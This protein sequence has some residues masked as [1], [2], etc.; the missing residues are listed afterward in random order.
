[1]QFNSDADSQDIVSDISFLTGVDTT[2]FTLKNRTLAVNGAL[3]IAWQIIFESYGGWKFMDD[4]QS[5]ATTG[6]P[7]ADQTITSG[8]GLYLLP[9]GTLTVDGVEFKPSASAPMQR[10]LPLTHEEFLQRGGDAAFPSNAV[11]LYYLIQGDVLR[12]LSTPNFT[13]ASA[14]RIFFS[15]AMTNFA[16]TDTTAAPGFAGIFHRYLSISAAYDWVSMRGPKEKA[17]VLLNLKQDYEKRMR[18]FYSKRFKDRFPHRINA[19]PD[20]VE[21]FS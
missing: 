16:S 5:D 4:N 6:L 21:Q 11:P 12:L 1:M 13:L 10:L 3:G 20:I 15:K 9:T 8:T 19:G 2:K 18:D 7:Y 14:L 17:P